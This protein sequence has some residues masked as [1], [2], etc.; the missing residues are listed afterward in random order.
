M[1]TPAVWPGLGF[2]PAPGDGSALDALD[3]RLTAGATALRG[4]G[5]SLNVLRSAAD[6]WKGAAAVAFA[7][8]VGPLPEHVDVATRS[9]DRAVA[10]LHEW[11]TVL[12]RLQIRARDLEERARIAREAVDTARAGAEAARR[13]PDLALAGQRFA[14]GPELD[15]AQRRLDAAQEAVQS[16]DAQLAAAQ[17]S[18]ERVLEHGHR[19]LAEHEAAAADTASA[20]GAA[21]EVLAPLERGFLDEVD[22]WIADN[23]GAIGDVAGVISAVAGTLALIPVLTPI[24]APIALIAGGVALA[25]H[26]IDLVANDKWTDANAWVTVVGDALGVVPGIGALAKGTALGVDALRVVDGLGD[27]AASGASFT[28]SALTHGLTDL[29]KGTTPFA[30]R[31]VVEV[32][33]RNAGADA[34]KAFKALGEATAT[35][36]GGDAVAWGKAQQGL[37]NLGLQVP[38]VQG[39][40]DGSPEVQQKKDQAG[41]GALGANAAQTGG[42]WLQGFSGTRD[43]WDS[44][45]RFARAVG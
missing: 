36:F 27:A 15:V 2:D 24:A 12:E 43:L 6:A 14:T 37:T 3:G 22:D 35:T 29:G 13:Q 26:A 33:E 19:L 7:R 25:A 42:T 34:A 28:R 23:A 21:G 5:E 40:F 1:T 11:H 31:F 30:D 16:A 20:M 32:T 10:V 4:A 38:T 41:W 44:V 45:G 17:E 9:L 39:W 8:Q 18:L